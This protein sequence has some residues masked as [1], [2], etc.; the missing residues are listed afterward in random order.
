MNDCDLK[1]LSLQQFVI[2]QQ[3]TNTDFDNWKLGGAVNTKKKI[4]KQFCNQAMGEGQKNF[5]EYDRKFLDCLIQTV[6]RNTNVNDSACERV[7]GSERVIGKWRKEDLSFIVAENFVAL[8]P[9]VLWKIELVKDGTEDISKQCV[10]LLL[11]VNLGK[12]KIN[13]RKN[14]LKTVGKT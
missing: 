5:E 13:R 8:C 4:W 11:I 14:C 6:S 10:F 12:K 3:K 2:Q 1:L 9:T 7:G